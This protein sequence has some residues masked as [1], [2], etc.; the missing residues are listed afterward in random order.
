MYKK[1]NSIKQ[2][3]RS[4]KADVVVKLLIKSFNCYVML[5]CFFFLLDDFMDKIPYFL[6]SVIDLFINATLV[7]LHSETG[8]FRPCFH[9]FIPHELHNT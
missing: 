1:L 8:A 7:R 2:R 4:C 3:T 5:F 9:V 6:T